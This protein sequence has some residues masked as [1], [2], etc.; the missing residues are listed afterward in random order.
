M[1][2]TTITLS[3]IEIDLS[4]KRFFIVENIIINVILER[5]KVRVWHI[6]SWIVEEKGILVLLLFEP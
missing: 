2:T 5:C 4:A 1:A 6:V 3:R